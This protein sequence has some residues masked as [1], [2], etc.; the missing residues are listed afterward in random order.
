[1]AAEVLDISRNQ[2]GSEGVRAI[3]EVIE[4][5]A[6]PR[7]KE[8]YIGYNGADADTREWIKRVA[9]AAGCTM[10]RA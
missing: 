9:K 2:L 10:V 4:A 5:G 8:L 6:L 7:L 3:G 1:M